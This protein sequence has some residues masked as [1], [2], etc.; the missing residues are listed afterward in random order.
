M[1]WAHFCSASAA[2]MHFSSLTTVG[3]AVRALSLGEHEAGARTHRRS[4]VQCVHFPRRAPAACASLRW[5]FGPRGVCTSIACSSAQRAIRDSPVR[6]MSPLP[7]L[8]FLPFPA[9][10]RS[11]AAE[12]APAEMRIEILPSLAP[13]RWTRATL[14]K[15]AHV[16]ASKALFSP[17]KSADFSFAL[18][19]PA[20]PSAIASS[21]YTRHAPGQ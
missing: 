10:E 16:R 3:R 2:R 7:R 1:Q 14:A 13:D 18:A 15:R 20:L 9:C 19:M 12:N 11:P 5:Q 21:L 4:P 8:I 17:S 6:G